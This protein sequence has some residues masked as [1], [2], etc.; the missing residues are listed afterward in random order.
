MPTIALTL[1]NNGDDAVVDQYNAALQIIQSLLNG[2]LDDDNISDEA[3]I[4]SKLS[5][6]VQNALVPVGL[7]SPYG[8][9]TA[10]NSAWL[11]CYGQAVSRSTYSALFAVVGTSFGVGDGST[12]FNLP[13]LRGRV[14]VGIDNLGGSAANT[15]QRSTTITT[16]SASATATPASMTGLSIGMKIVST[17]VPAGTTITAVGASTITMSANA[18]A[19]AAGTAVR[20]SMTADA[21]VIGSTGG[22]DVHTLVTEQLPAHTHTQIGRIA[23]SGATNGLSINTNNNATFQATDTTGSTGS[24]R[25]HPNMQPSQLVSY[26]IKV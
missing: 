1:P 26:I 9:S 7:I 12:T 4:L 5:T 19:S 3:V 6:A 20:F 2:G 17:N 8:G 15:I 13:D 18:T 24:D 23:S 16:T 25:A 10:P 22:T 11:L 21:N 14:P